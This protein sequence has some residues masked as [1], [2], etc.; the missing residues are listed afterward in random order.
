MFGFGMPEVLIMAVICIAAVLPTIF[1]LYCLVDIIKSEFQ[2]NNKIIWLLVVIFV[3]LLGM[4][5]YY[6]F[7]KKQ[8]ITSYNAVST[9]LNGEF[10]PSCGSKTDNSA[11][12]C[13]Q[14]GLAQ[15][16]V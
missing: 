10:C 1:W 14:C 15:A 5:L 8:K 13:K 4:I 6:S 9:A 12:F 7:G 2:G 11:K 3:P 16:L